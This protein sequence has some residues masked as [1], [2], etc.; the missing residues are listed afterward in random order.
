[1]VNKINIECKNIIA[2]GDL[3]GYFN[4]L[5]SLIK[6]YD[7]E[8]TCIIVCGDCGLG[9]YKDGYYKTVFNNL[10]E[11]CRKHNITVVLVRGNHDD[12]SYFIDGKANT[13]HIVAVPDYTVINGSILCVGGATSIDRIVRLNSEKSKMEHYKYYHPGATEEEVKEN[14][15]RYY[16]PDEQP[17]FDTDKLDEIASEGINIRTVITH[18]CPSFCYPTDKHGMDYWMS[19]DE[20]LE[21]DIDYERKVMDRLYNK[22]KQD[23]HPVTQ[24]FYGHYHE[25]KRYEHEGIDFCLLDGVVYE[26]GNIDCIGIKEFENN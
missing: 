9:F 21:S 2:T 7:L 25:H 22:L 6:R 3:H 12:P 1:M 16:W 14:A 11:M 10:E 19:Y 26:G 8:D 24:W 17:F 18:T 23:G 5:K 13:K 4:S 20:N 15:V